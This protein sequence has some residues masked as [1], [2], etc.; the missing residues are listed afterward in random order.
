MS[1]V[2]I[3]T[4]LLNCPFCGGDASKWDVF[5]KNNGDGQFVFFTGCRNM[6]CFIN[7]RL[8]VEG[9]HGISREDDIPNEIAENLSI[10]NWNL[11]SQWKKEP[12][13]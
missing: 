3:K 4:E 9:Q 8:V 10:K 13:K 11:R 6:E 7:P 2:Q 1:N 12:T 5:M